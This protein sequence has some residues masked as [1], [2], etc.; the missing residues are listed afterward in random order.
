MPPVPPLPTLPTLRV[1][2][3][4]WAHR[5]W[6]GTFYPAGTRPGEELSE[7][8]TWCTAVEGNTTFYALPPAE[9]VARWAAMAPAEFRFLFKVPRSITHEQRLRGTDAELLAFLRVLAPLGERLGPVS[10]QLPPSFGPGDLG[11][12]AAFLRHAPQQVRWSVEVRHP[13]FFDGSRAEAALERLLAETGSERVLM[14]TTTLFAHR[15]VDDAERETWAQKPRV[16]ARRRAVTDAPVVR[17]IGRTDPAATIEG[18]QPWLAVVVD[19][20]EEGRTPTVFVHT[21]DN[22]AALML[23]RRFHDDARILAAGRGLVVAPLPTPNAA[24]FVVQE[25]LFD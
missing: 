2:T 20:L 18:W 9:T 15:P 3:A 17:Y 13:D 25:R 6:V 12:L 22:L 7:Y 24:P 11:V 8:V 21:P 14:D 1:G 5:G 16:P 10:I 19:W 23:A 4:L